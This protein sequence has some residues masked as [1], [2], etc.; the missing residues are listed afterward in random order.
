MIGGERT[1]QAKKARLKRMKWAAFLGFWL[2]SIALIVSLL[3]DPSSDLVFL[4]SIG[5]LI[6]GFAIRLLPG[7]IL[8][9]RVPTGDDGLS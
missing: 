8:P 7:D 9:W 2:S 6:S 1:P 5:V 3:I 4:F